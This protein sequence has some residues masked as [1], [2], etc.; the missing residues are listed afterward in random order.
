MML[1]AWIEQ[2]ATDDPGAVPPELI[3]RLHRQLDAMPEVAK[4]PELA[5]MKG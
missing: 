1:V 4:G 5:P 2:Q 3:R